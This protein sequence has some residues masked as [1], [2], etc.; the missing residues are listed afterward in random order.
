[1]LFACIASALL[2]HVEATFGFPEIHRGVLPGL[3]SVVTRR[4]LDTATCERLMCMRD[5]IGAVEG[6]RVSLVDFV[7]THEELLGMHGLY[8]NLVMSS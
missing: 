7:G 6:V 4:R 3:V 5:A 8:M 1:M 2:A